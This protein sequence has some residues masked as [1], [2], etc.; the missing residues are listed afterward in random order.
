MAMVGFVS[1]SPAHVVH[2]SHWCGK[3]PLEADMTGDY[4]LVLGGCTGT[5]A[6]YTLTFNNNNDPNYDTTNNVLNST[7]VAGGKLYLLK[8]ALGDIRMEVKALDGDA[9]QLEVYTVAFKNADKIAELTST[10][11][12]LGRIGYFT[13]SG[14]D[15]DCT[16]AVLTKTS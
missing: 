9:V 5:T 15:I 8:Y 1:A 7:P 4:Q 11:L 10:G 3:I 12:S 6:T 14:T 2:P 16:T 13:M